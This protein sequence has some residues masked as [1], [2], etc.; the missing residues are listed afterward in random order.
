MS[1][2][3]SIL[4]LA[5]C[6]PALAA[7]GSSKTSGDTGAQSADSHAAQAI[8][9]ANCIR[10]HGVPSFPD[11]G[12]S[13]GGIQIQA[14]QR[15]GSG[16]TLTVNGVSVSAPAFQA[17]M[18]ACQSK[19]PKAQLPPGGLASIRAASLKFAECMRSHGVPNFPDPQ[20]QS[21]PG[22][23]VGVKVGGPGSGI[24]PNSPAFQSAQ[25]AC[26]SLF[27]GAGPKLAA[28]GG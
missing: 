21:G 11:P 1:R 26:G 9:Y 4:M 20:I 25:K 17:A 16:G 15:S 18:K 12:N 19:M 7:C 14:S 28:P 22:G 5:A 13:K 24:Q 6:V 3:L 2:F 8:A 23:G 27:G 10:T